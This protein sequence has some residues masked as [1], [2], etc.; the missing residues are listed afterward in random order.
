[1]RRHR[2]AGESLGPYSLNFLSQIL[3]ICLRIDPIL[4][5]ILRICL[6]IDPILSLILRIRLRIELRI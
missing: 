1:M 3:R 4:R 6:R 2:N 5:I